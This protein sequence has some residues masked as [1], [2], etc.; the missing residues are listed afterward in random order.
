MT[1]DYLPFE[2][3]GQPPAAIEGTI[4]DREPA[5]AWSGVAPLASIAARGK[6]LFAGEAKLWVRGV[7]YGA[8]RPD[9]E[10]RE[11]QDAARLERDFSMM[12]ANGINTVRIPHTTPPRHLL[13]VAGRHGLRVMVGLSAE[14]QVGHLIDRGRVPGLQAL[15]RHRV[16]ECRGHPALLCYAVGNEIP[17]PIVRWLGR[18]RVVRYLESI[19]R[20][21]KD[22]DPDALVT[23]V[24]YPTT[25]YLE[26]PFLDIVSFN[27]YLEEESRFRA[28]LARLQSVSGERPLLMTELGLDSMRNGVAGQAEA[29]GWQLRATREAGCAGA[30][31]FAWTDEWFRGGAEVDDWAFGL[32]DRER[33]P[34]P[35]LAAVRRS[36]REP[37]PPPDAEPPRV[38]V[39]VCS[40]NGARTIGRCLDG[41]MRLDYRDYEV[42]VVDDGSTDGTAAIA[43]AYPVR[44]IR[45]PN[46]GLSAARNTGMEAATGAI[47]AY[48]DDDA[49]PDPDWLS[50]LA[51]AFI[52]PRVGAAG[53]PNLPPPDGEPVTACMALAP[54]T[55]THVLLTDTLA[56]HVPGC[57]KAVRREVLTALGGFDPEFRI[58]GDDVDFCWR[59]QDAGWT[60]GFAPAAQVWHLRRHTIAAY[61]RQQV[62]YGRAEAL[63]ERKW[64]GR[65]NGAGHPSWAGRIY[66]A[67]RVW[68]GPWRT[69]V[70]HGVWGGAPFQRLYED[71][72]APWLSLP[73]L[74]EWHLVVAAL[75][76]AALLGLLWPPLS[77]AIPLLV[78]AA[79][80]V[81]ARALLGAR[82]ALRRRPL[83]R[84]PAGLARARMITLVVLLH[85]LQPLARLHGR[86]RGGLSPWRRVGNGL[87]WPRPRRWALWTA[88]SGTPEAH[89]AWLDG[90]LRDDGIVAVHGDAYDRWDLGVRLGPTGDARL[91]MAI[92]DHGSGHQ[93]VRVRW[94]PWPRPA[95]LVGALV[96]AGLAA[97]AAIDGAWLVAAV[98]GTS[99]A[100]ALAAVGRDTASA[101]AA[102]EHAVDRLRQRLEGDDHG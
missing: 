20:I 92:E 99:G 5:A 84:R 2:P 98:L 7:T 67:G 39:V 25:E 16:R 32:T 100:A 44:L 40:Y 6:F 30:V 66:D 59:L 15:I 95:P 86:L 46:R 19:Y 14:Q 50:F 36:F 38:S 75:A 89:L 3:P 70:Y 88:R 41:L 17:A 27:V 71:R 51:A 61:W 97:A 29:L 42:I 55:A 8:F 65:F 47:I 72:L 21:V 87:T 11:Y 93:Y 85:A 18:S 35:A 83:P 69:R 1:S 82:D 60:I 62:N 64:P 76:A 9:A 78:V 74:P 13:D 26:L 37:A 56:E 96:F 10:G 90:T 79:A 57:N 33:R 58:A 53:G 24:N 48:L 34:K 12:A 4:L 77:I 81:P 52:D 45:T 54:G 94:W 22:E 49:W 101:Q 43:S 91:L 68:L 28:Y 31:V 23:Y 102:L 73:L 63:L 80:V